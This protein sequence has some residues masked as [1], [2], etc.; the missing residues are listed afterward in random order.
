MII[1]YFYLNIIITPL[2]G[3]LGGA[4]G[5][6]STKVTNFTYFTYY[7]YYEDNINIHIG[8]TFLLMVSQKNKPKAEDIQPK[9]F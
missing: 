2:V 3:G 6:P 4:L 1:K 7:Y 8:K 9:L 5:L